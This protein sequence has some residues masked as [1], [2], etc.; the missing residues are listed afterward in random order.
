MSA[1]SANQ[2]HYLDHLGIDVWMSRDELAA[3]TA[4]S[5]TPQQVPQAI[6]SAPASNTPVAEPF[7]DPAPAFQQA[8]A[9]SQ[10]VTSQPAMPKP[11]APAPTPAPVQQP[12]ADLN[13]AP[14]N[15]PSNVAS[16]VS[17]PAFP[18]QAHSQSAGVEGTDQKTVGVVAPAPEFNLQFWCYGSTASDGVWI[19]SDESDLTREHHMFAHNLAQ[20]VEGKKRKPKHVGIFSWPMLDA[21]NVDQGEQVAQHY[22]AQHIEQLQNISAKKTIIA[23]KGCDAWLANVPHICLPLTLSEV[24]QN[25]QCKRTIWQQLL[26][27]K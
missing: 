16:P 19:V 7:V 8:T 1:L 2:L 17:A 25:P 18:S 26:A 24:L 4:D 20:F 27:V 13:V 15:A 11:I 5:S 21:P 10:S 22:L 9:E 3:L 12:A 23:F 6:D 14:T